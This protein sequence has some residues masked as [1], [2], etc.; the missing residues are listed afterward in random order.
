MAETVGISGVSRVMFRCYS[1][2]EIWG[3][4]GS[5]LFSLIYRSIFVI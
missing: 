4:E 1:T 3:H 5:L 2:L